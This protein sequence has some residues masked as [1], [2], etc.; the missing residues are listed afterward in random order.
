MEM[1][2]VRVSS[3][4]CESSLIIPMLREKEKRK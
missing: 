4:G 2:G 1:G 3:Q